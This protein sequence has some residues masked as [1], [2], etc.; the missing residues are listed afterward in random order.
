MWAKAYRAASALGRNERGVSTTLI[1]TADNPGFLDQVMDL[2]VSVGI[3]GMSVCIVL[4]CV[5]EWR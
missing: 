2:Y 3:G 5:C 1:P 4:Y